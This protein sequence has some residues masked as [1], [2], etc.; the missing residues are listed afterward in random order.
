MNETGT[1]TLKEK[2][3]AEDKFSL[4]DMDQIWAAYNHMPYGNVCATHFE[5]VTRRKNVGGEGAT[6]DIVVTAEQQYR[7]F[8]ASDYVATFVGGKIEKHKAIVY[9]G[10][11]AALRKNPMAAA[12]V[13]EWAIKGGLEAFMPEGDKPK[14]EK[15]EQLETRI[16]GLEAGQ[17]TL[18][19]SMKA[20]ADALN[21]LAQAIT[22]L[23]GK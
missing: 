5:T 3:E 12:I 10:S 19:E 21:S 18:A 6:Q 13:I 14:K 20:Q 23:K 4:K 2:T 7:A 15:V 17:L 1:E 22:S 11:A 8:L 9:Q 16:A